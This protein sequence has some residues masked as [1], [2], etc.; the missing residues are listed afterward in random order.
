M[1]HIANSNIRVDNFQYRTQD[2]TAYVYFLSHCHEGKLPI[3]GPLQVDS[4]ACV[5]IICED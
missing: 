1:S 4:V 5:Q 2:K 3:A